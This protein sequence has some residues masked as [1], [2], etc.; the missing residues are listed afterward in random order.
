VTLPARTPFTVAF[1]LN[2]SAVSNVGIVDVHFF[3][4][5]PPY[6]ELGLRYG[7]YGSHSFVHDYGDSVGGGA[8]VGND[9]AIEPVAAATWT[10]VAVAITYLTASTHAVVTYD[11]VS[12]WQ[13][14]VPADNYNA[15]SK[16]ISLGIGSTEHAGG[17][18]TVQIDNVVVTSP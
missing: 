9:F 8:T 13:D 5:K 14:D 6:Y 2:V 4:L 3:Y 1:D 7:D 10:R 16:Y 18:V 17:A 15:T 11:G 12:K